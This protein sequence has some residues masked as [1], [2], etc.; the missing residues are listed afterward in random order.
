MGR[1]A[2][3]AENSPLGNVCADGSFVV[4]GADT[5]EQADELLTKYKK[6]DLDFGI[7]AKTLKDLVGLSSDEEAA[8]IVGKLGNK[9]GMCVERAPHRA[10]AASR[11]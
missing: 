11:P 10:V 9:S 3:A 7:D 8:A 5:Q 2:D 4:G 6:K 1:C